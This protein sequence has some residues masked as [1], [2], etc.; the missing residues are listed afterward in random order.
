MA[1]V[2][3]AARV[4]AIGTT[5]VRA[6]ESA[7]TTGERAGRTRLLI[8]GDYRWK[9]VDVLL[10]NFHLPRSTLLLLVESFIGPR[11]RELYATA[12]A[13]GYR[14]LSFGDAMLMERAR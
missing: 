5:T 1:A 8:H 2:E 14:F 3:R 13:E 9:V 11:W 7:A 12:L 10:T 6:L 4:V